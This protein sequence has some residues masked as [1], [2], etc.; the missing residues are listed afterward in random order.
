MANQPIEQPPILTEDD[1]QLLDDIWDT[2]GSEET[3]E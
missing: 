2:I 3:Q 1:E